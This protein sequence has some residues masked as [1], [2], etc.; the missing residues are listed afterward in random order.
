M[1]FRQKKNSV[2]RDE[3]KKV[4]L[5]WSE[6]KQLDKHD[7]RLLYVIGKLLINYP[8]S[9]SIEFIC[10]ALD[11]SMGNSTKRTYR[12]NAWSTYY[13]EERKIEDKKRA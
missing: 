13:Q 12:I 7:E 10:D 11:I 5:K 3:L 9:F 4:G 6:A 8:V 2:L 1:N